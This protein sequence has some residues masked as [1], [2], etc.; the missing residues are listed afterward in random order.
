[1]KYKKIPIVGYDVLN[2]YPVYAENMYNGHE[3]LKIVGI[4]E[5]EV[6]LEGDYS[7]MNNIIG[8]QWFNKKH[9]FVVKSLCEESLKIGGCRLHNLHCC[10]GGSVISKHTDYWKS[11]IN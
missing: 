8:K 10:G 11:I 2:M 5:H 7:G 1:M 9:V 3:P 6:E 4:R